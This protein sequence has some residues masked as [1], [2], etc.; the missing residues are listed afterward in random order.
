MPF[1]F[2]LILTPGALQ[3]APHTHIAAVYADR[4]AEP[5]LDR[6]VADR[7]SITSIHA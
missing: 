4:A 3:G 6:A 7:F 1:D 5:M 2:A